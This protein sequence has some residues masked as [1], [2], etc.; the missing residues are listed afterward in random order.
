M[1]ATDRWT[2]NLDAELSELI[3]QPDDLSA[4]DLWRV[5][6]LL[7]RVAQHPTPSER[8]ESLANICTSSGLTDRARAGAARPAEA[9]VLDALDD[10]LLVDEDPAGPLADALLEI[11]DLVSVLGLEGQDSAAQA[12]VDQAVALMDLAPVPASALDEWAARRLAVLDEA[13]PAAQLW[14][15]VAGAGASAVVHSLPAAVVPH[16][17]IAA[18]LDRADRQR[19]LAQVIELFPQVPTVRRAVRPAAADAGAPWK[20]AEGDGWTVY[21]DGGDTIA[22]VHAPAGSR[23]P[24]VARLVVATG[25]QTWTEPV[26]AFRRGERTAWFRLGDEAELARLFARARTELGVAPEVELS[27]RFEW[28]PDE[29][30]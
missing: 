16:Q 26:R 17:G 30:T 8:L 2:Q 9:T 20:A 24:Q 22:Q 12:I 29:G 10:A 18:L 19:P 21:E 7:A 27:V 15:A 6:V 25:K 3:A 5:L 4:A 1:S 11:D 28:E 23:P 14:Q 13:E